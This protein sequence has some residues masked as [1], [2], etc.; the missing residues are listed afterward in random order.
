MA[1]PWLTTQAYVAQDAQVVPF[2]L[3]GFAPSDAAAVLRQQ[4]S[5]AEVR[6][7]RTDPHG[8]PR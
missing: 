8:D 6:L 5:A 2:E 4:A 3:A 7:L 1:V